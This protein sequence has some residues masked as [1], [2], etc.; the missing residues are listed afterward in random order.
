[1]SYTD[2]SYPSKQDQIGLREDSA[3]QVA[4]KGANLSHSYSKGTACADILQGKEMKEG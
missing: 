1:M 2:R 3:F 4:R